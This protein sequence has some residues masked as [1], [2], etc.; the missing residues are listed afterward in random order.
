MTWLGYTLAQWALFFF[1]YSFLGWIWESCY[2]SVREGRWINRGFLHGPFLPIYG[3]GAVSILMFT[4]PVAQSIPL[5]FFMGMAGATLL[6]YITGYTMERLFLVRYWD[7]SMYRWNLNG[8]ICLPA[9]LCWG[10][11]SLLL[12]R[13][14]HP[15][16]SNWVSA[17][18]AVAATSAALLLAT[19]LLADTLLSMREAVDMRSILKSLSESHRRIAWLQKRYEVQAAFS[20]NEFTRGLDNIQRS[21]AFF[22]EALFSRLQSLRED[23]RQL[24][25]AL[26]H[27]IR[28]SS[29][30]DA[31]VSTN[32]VQEELGAMKTRTDFMY[33]RM[34]RHLRRNPGLISTQ[35]SDALLD[36]NP[37]LYP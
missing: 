24:L 27:K 30:D 12:I 8:Y 2:V 10:A 22:R 6:E 15:I 1:L 35:H 23:R 9:S 4:L 16:L 19:A 29:Q 32:L 7:Y 5:V 18:P 33:L 3:F 21:G 11:F 31:L 14:V 17:L 28:V 13:L 20:P 37:L 26:D 25:D 36:V 34:V